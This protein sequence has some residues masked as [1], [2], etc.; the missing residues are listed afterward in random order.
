MIGFSFPAMAYHIETSGWTDGKHYDYFFI[1]WSETGGWSSGLSGGDIN[2][3]DGYVIVMPDPGDS[4]YGSIQVKI[5]YYRYP[6]WDYGWDNFYNFL[7]PYNGFSINV[8]PPDFYSEIIDVMIGEYNGIF[9]RASTPPCA[10]INIYS[11]PTVADP[12]QGYAYADGVGGISYFG[13]TAE[14][15]GPVPE[16]TTMLLLGLALIGFTGVR[17]I[18]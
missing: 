7:E 1:S 2:P 13:W 16:P 11:Y 5:S 3:A 18:F 8:P 17:K 12:S 9:I 6:D 15:I 4:M 14:M 10:T